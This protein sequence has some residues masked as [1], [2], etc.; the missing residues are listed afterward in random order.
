MDVHATKKTQKGSPEPT[1]EEVASKLTGR[2]LQVY[3]VLL[4]VGEI[5]VRELQKRLGLSSPSVAHFYLQKIADLGLARGRGGTYRLTRKADLP[6]LTTWVLVGQNI[7][8]KSAFAATFV[9]ILLLG[10]LSFVYATWNPDSFFA[11][12]I[13]A[14]AM[15]YLWFDAISQWK[16]KPA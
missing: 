9:T 7:L 3:L 12:L 1:R 4:N 13:G 11:I 5:G 16:R 10:Y 6:V 8:P 14:A 2:T 15:F